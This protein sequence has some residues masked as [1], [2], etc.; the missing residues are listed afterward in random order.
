MS[1]ILRDSLTS[2]SSSSV[3]PSSPWSDPANGTTLKAMGCVYTSAVR[4]SPAS[5]VALSRR[6]PSIAFFPVPETDW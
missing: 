6:R 4:G 3:Y 5:A 1:M 2:L